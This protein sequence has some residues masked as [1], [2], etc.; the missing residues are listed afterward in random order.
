[1]SD[2]TEILAAPC[3]FCGYD[4][5]AYWQVGTH[6]KNCPWHKWGWKIE[7][8]D[9]L[10]DVIRKL[11]L[12]DKC[13]EDA[14]KHIRIAYNI[15]ETKNFNNMSKDKMICMLDMVRQAIKKTV[16]ENDR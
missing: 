2:I 4:G 9:M 7:R 1:M 10:P 6:D 14:T 15:I 3:I 12:S 5:Q 16:E 13:M 8:N 11:Y